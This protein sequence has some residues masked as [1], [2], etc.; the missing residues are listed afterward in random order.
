MCTFRISFSLEGCFVEACDPDKMSAAGNVTAICTLNQN[1]L[2]IRNQTD[3]LMKCFNTSDQKVGN[4]CIDCVKEFNQIA[5]QYKQLGESS[6][7]IC[8]DVVDQVMEWP[9]GLL[10]K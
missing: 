4:S 3:E 10:K 9:Y 2:D 5:N 6:K 7:G 1:V 8:F